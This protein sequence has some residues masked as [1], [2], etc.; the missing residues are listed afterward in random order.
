V[1]WNEDIVSYKVKITFTAAQWMVFK[2]YEG[3]AKESRAF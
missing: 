1:F 3:S 2:A